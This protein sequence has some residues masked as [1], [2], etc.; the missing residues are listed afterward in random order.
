MCFD[1]SY[2]NVFICNRCCNKVADSLASYGRCVLFSGSEPL[3][4]GAPEFVNDLIAGDL[5]GC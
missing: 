2:C 5:P 4:T 1:F 3:M